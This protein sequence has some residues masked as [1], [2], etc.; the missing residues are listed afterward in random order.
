M[1]KLIKDWKKL[2]TAV[3]QWKFILANKAQVFLHLDNDTTY[4]EFLNDAGDHE[5][6]ADWFQM[7]ES[8][9]NGVGSLLE[10]LGIEGEN[11]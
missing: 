9:G 2:K 1:K 3:D 8:V 4:V 5:E 7:K 10:A 11:V 6:E